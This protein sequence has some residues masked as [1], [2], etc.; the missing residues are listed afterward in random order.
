MGGGQHISL[1]KS[2]FLEITKF[3]LIK[4]HSN[5]QI[6]TEAL[7]RESVFCMTD[8]TNDP[9]FSP[10]SNFSPDCLIHDSCAYVHCVVRMY[11]L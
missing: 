7:S 6:I 8:S 4:V 3:L 11:I 1:Y 2:D 9:E 5:G 10:A